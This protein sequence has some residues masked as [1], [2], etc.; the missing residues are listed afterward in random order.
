MHLI[1]GLGNPGHRYRKT[2][3]NVGF[4]LLD[5]I[6]DRAGLAFRTFAGSSLVCEARIADTEVVLAKPQTFMNRSG[7]AV[8]DLIRRFGAETADCLIVYDE[9]ALPLGKIRFKRNGSAGGHNGMRSIIDVLG[10]PEFP[11][12][13]IGIQGESVIDDLSDYVL[14]KFKLKERRQLREILP[15]GADGIEVFIS[16]GIDRAM[17]AYN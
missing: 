6:A 2:R 17:A 4:M 7:L 3:H 15:M 14:S 10:T 8:R 1:V 11:R 12:L 13:R 16:E 9:V 5:L